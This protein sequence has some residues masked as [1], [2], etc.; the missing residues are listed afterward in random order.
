MA[1]ETGQYGDILLAPGLAPVEHIFRLLWDGI[2]GSGI[3]VIDFK[4]VRT[5]SPLFAFLAPRRRILGS[6]VFT[7]RL[8][9]S[10][11]ENFE[12]YW[13]SRSASMRKNLRRARRKL[14][15]VGKVTYEVIRDPDLLP[16]A[17]RQVIEHKH[18]WLRARG[19]RSDFLMK[20]EI[21]DWM[22][23]VALKALQSGNLHLSV[24]RV[25]GQIIS[26]QCAFICKDRFTAYMS[27]FDLDYSVYAAGKIQ[28]QSFFE[29]VFDQGLTIDLMPYHEHFK[30]DWVDL[31]V[32]TYSCTV[33]VSRLGR[34]ISTVANPRNRDLIKGLYWRLPEGIRNFIATPR[35][36]QILRKRKDASD[37]QD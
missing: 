16:A 34:L 30:R 12:A 3:D 29:D 35:S 9:T 1:A 14:E 10:K 13:K 31:G 19:L 23:D 27:T 5:D 11:Y 36:Y 32:A 8:D 18:D 26:S 6:E 7:H 25:D 17:F 24:V 21:F 33:P 20:P 4:K 22:S 2:V 15:G 37:A 28:Y